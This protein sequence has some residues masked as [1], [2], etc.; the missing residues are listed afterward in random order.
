MNEDIEKFL[1]GYLD[2]PDPQYAVFLKGNWGCGK[3]FFINKW[4]ESY[5]K[6]KHEDQVLEPVMV[7][8]YGLSDIK[9]IT[10]AINRVL[11]PI[12]YGKAAKAGKT[13]AKFVS[14]IVFKHEVD[15]DNDGNSDLEMNIGLDSLSIFSSDNDCVKKGKLL[16][17]DDIERSEVPMKKLLGFLN[18]FVEQCHSHLIIIGDENKIANIEQKNV[19]ADFKEKTIGREFE[20]DANVEDAIKYFAEEKPTNGFVVS[21]CPAIQKVFSKTGCKNL[22]ILRQ[23][24]WDFGRFEET[25]CEYANDDR[26]EEVMTHIMDAY[27]I[28]YCEYRGASHEFLDKWVR[29]NSK[30]EYQD[31]INELRHKI[32]YLHQRYNNYRF[33]SYQTFDIEMVEKIIVELNTG[34][35]IK[36]YV[37]GYFVPKEKIK[38]WEKISDYYKM[39]D[40]DFLDF[41]NE[42]IEDICN[43]RV[44]GFRKLGYAIAFLVDLDSHDTKEIDNDD[45]NRLCSVLPEYL[46]K[47]D[48]VDYLYDAHLEFERG[49]NRYTHHGKSD[50]LA[51]LCA[52]FNEEYQ[53]QLKKGK[54]IMTRTLESLSDE[55]V[56][57]LCEINDN[58]LPDH[59]RTYDMVSIFNSVDIR[60]L[61]NH[62]I[63]LSNES[64]WAFNY[65][66]RDRYK[67]SYNVGN[68]LHETNDDIEPLLNLKSMIDEIL[69]TKKFV[70]KEAFSTI[71]ESLDGAIKRCKGDLHAMEI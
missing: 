6:K 29:Y 50:K 4:L 67:L 30:G 39:E 46:K 56:E 9:Q 53:N 42:L 38:S 1:N 51:Q 62:L 64:L 60:K 10:T 34:T 35:S 36:D 21:H 2:N 71:S 17:F 40:Q 48:K 58:A 3:T 52:K 68:W 65:F 57:S 43:I 20:I 33:T 61:F 12:L 11:Y 22:R 69:P 8:L 24:L 13:I 54:N 19:F 26:Y 59:S 45:F 47:V 66:I 37:K 27:I 7:S 70:Q 41:Y 28:T 44:V 16:I 63:R 25:M 14:A 5:K 31:E 15:F 18:Y 49:I 32:G 23:A 55:N